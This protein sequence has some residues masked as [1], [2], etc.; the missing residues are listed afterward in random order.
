MLKE[1]F[2]ELQQR[3]LKEIRSFY[4]RRLVSVVIFGSVARETYR[5]NSDID[6]LIVAEDLPRGRMKRV[7]EFSQVE[8]QVEPFL[9][10]LQKEGIDT[11]ISPVFKTP[12]E[13]E[14]G[15][16]LFLDMVEDACILYDENDFFRRRL[17]RL[18][19]R[20]KELGAK[21]IWRGSTWHWVLKPDYKPGEVIEL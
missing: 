4:G 9:E 3:L 15:S 21:R 1:N 13:V 7:K 17:D 10:S 5:Y 20:L 16:P 11:Y 12:G 8:D 14:S 6:I 2:R 19:K 18:R